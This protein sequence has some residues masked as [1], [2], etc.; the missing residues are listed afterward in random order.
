MELLTPSG[1]V[2]VIEAPVRLPRTFRLPRLAPIHLVSAVAV[3]ALG[4]MVNHKRT[5]E[6]RLRAASTPASAPVVAT[7]AEVSAL[8]ATT[9]ASFAA[10]VPVSPAAF[11]GA[12][13]RLHARILAPAEPLPEELVPAIGRAIDAPGVYGMMT[14]AGEPSFALIRM[15]PFTDKV[16]GKVGAYEVGYW[17]GEWSRTSAAYEAPVG[18]IEVTKANQDTKVSEH[19]RLRDFITHDQADVWPKVVVLREE[20]VDKVELVLADLEKR[21]I[22]TNRVVV[23]SGFRTPQYNEALGDASGRAR[24]SRHQYGDAADLLIDANGD[25]RMDDLDRD[26]RIGAGD[27]RVIAQAVERVELMH[28]ELV[29]GLGVYDA[30]HASGVFAHIDVRGTRARWSRE[31]RPAPR[32]AGG[33][34][35]YASAGTVVRP[36]VRGKCFATGASAILCGGATR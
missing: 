25:G 15:R 34:V 3:L 6:A 14:P 18:F 33:Q 10:P 29:G 21:G 20:L 23:R 17:K 31:A 11:R 27:L 16:G 28:P 22:A 12:S 19:L 2:A 26:G 30:S 9:T 24:E 8:E 35:V 36:R 7:S 13:G 5:V 4:A 32:R 1:T